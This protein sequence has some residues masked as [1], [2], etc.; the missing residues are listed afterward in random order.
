MPRYVSVVLTGP[1]SVFRVWTRR[2]GSD[3]K[4]YL[5]RPDPTARPDNSY[6]LTFFLRKTR[7]MVIFRRRL[8]RWLTKFS[9]VF[10]TICPTF[11]RF[12]LHLGVSVYVEG[13]KG[14]ETRR[15]DRGA[16]LRP[17]V[18]NFLVMGVSARDSRL[19]KSDGRGAA[20]PL[21]VG[22]FCCLGKGF[23]PPG[24]RSDTVR[25]AG[26]CSATPGRRLCHEGAWPLASRSGRSGGPD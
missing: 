9:V 16:A 23:W 2:L 19:G 22:N 3:L 4:S 6:Y 7:D 13:K 20:L 21:P 17:A 24:A 15:T 14:R 8:L 26:S 18:G 25:L 12:P 5:A 10:Y 1:F 11:F